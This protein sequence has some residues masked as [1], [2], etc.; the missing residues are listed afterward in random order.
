MPTLLSALI[1]DSPLGTL[2]QRDPA[3]RDCIL[4]G[5]VRKPSSPLA[6][7]R[8]A[9]RRRLRQSGTPNVR[10]TQLAIS[11]IFGQE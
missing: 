9:G 7:I 11:S 4:S 8:E 1:R 3:R 10:G 2:G 6:G 5:L